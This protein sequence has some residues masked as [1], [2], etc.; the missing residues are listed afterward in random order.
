MG[1]TCGAEGLLSDGELDLRLKADGW[2]GAGGKE[3]AHYELVQAALVGVP[4]LVG[5]RGGPP[6][7]VDRRV[8]MVIMTSPPWRGPHLS[9]VYALCVRPPTWIVQMLSHERLCKPRQTA[10]TIW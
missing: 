6:R 4:P 7:G 3:A 1:H 9:A 8:G 10:E 2:L 5:V